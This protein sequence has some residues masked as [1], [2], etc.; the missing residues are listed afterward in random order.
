M[1]QLHRLSGLA[2]TAGDLVHELQRE[3]GGTAIYLGTQGRQFGAELQA[4]R[5][6]TDRRIERFETRLQ[7]LGRGDSDAPTRQRIDSAVEGLAGLAAQR[8]RVD[9]LDASA[10]QVLGR[11]TDLNTELIG[12][13]G[14]LSHVTDEAQTT[15]TLA[16]YYS[17]LRAKELAGIERALLSSAF[18]ADRIDGET[19]QRFVSLIGAQEAQLNT[20]QVLASQTQRA[21][22]DEQ[23]AGPEIERLDALRGVVLQSAERQGFG[24]DPEEWFEWQ[25]VKIDRLKVVEDALADSV[26]ALVA[27]L[28]DGARHDLVRNGVIAA[29]IAGLVVLV[30]LL[31]GRSTVLRLRQTAQA[32]REIAEGDGDLTRRLSVTHHD[33]IGSL[34][35][36]FNAFAARMQG[37]LLDVKESAQRVYSSAEEIAQGS[38]ALAARTEQEAS[39]LQ[40]TS[41]SMEQITATVNHS[42]DSAQQADALALSTAQVARRGE[43]AM[44]EVGGTMKDISASA[45]R[46]VEIITLIDSIAF[47]TN[48]LALNASVEAARA[49]EHGRGFA[50]VAQEVRVLASRS[51]DAAQEIRQLIDASVVHTQRG[52]EIVQHAGATMEEIVQSVERVTGVIAEIS[53]GAR[54]QSAGIVQ[55]NQAVSE[56]DGNTQRNV[57]LVEQTSNA[58]ADM[59]AQAEHLNV[60][61]SA[62]VLGQRDRPESDAG[63][64]L[65]SPSREPLPALA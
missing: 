32:M 1:N 35:T 45:E 58:A 61:M 47:Q 65:P 39:S 63:V 15:R 20:F 7:A 55:V 34:A 23:L 43:A 14:Q 57:A 60:L 24:V 54:E 21:L 40:E 10:G 2:L 13:V 6:Q 22:L 46:I 36:Q 9:E 16:A 37:L 31:I 44:Q 3:R 25:S 51:G 59:R 27:G 26:L 48:I 11:Y 19:Y 29:V 18:G 17:L 38:E 41:A 5:A 8:Q 56:L 53:A 42:A 12:I 52:A 30:A 33:E 64:S 4:Q 49:G 28:R 62:F 50:V